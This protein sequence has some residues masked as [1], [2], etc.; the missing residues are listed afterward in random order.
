MD[1]TSTPPVP[2]RP[3]TTPEIARTLRMLVLWAVVVPAA[4]VTGYASLIAA[5]ELAEDGGDWVGIGYVLAAFFGV[6]ALV[7]GGLAA[8]S[9]VLLRRRPA[10][11]RGLALACSVAVVAVNVVFR[12]VGP[13]GLLPG[14]TGL[15]LALLTALEGRRR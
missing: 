6:P 8:A 7:V 11:S 3:V 4:G 2:A 10:V 9:L 5:A 15:A 12:E 14:V 1:T 13:L